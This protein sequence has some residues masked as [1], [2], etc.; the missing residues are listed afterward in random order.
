MIQ[1]LDEHFSMKQRI[2]ER[3]LAITKILSTEHTLA[4]KL[5]SMFHMDNMIPQFLQLPKDK[6]NQLPI[7]P[8]TAVIPATAA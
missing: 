3:M 6:K 1:D 5:S 2:R 4:D 8:A 7:L